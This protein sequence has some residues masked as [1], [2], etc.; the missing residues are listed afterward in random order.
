MSLSAAGRTAQQLRVEVAF[1]DSFGKD[2]STQGY[3]SGMERR[4]YCFTDSV[5][6]DK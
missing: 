4:A 1:E 3:L 5:Q 6:V 2:K